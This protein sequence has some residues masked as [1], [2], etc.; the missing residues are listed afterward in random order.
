MLTAFKPS[1]ACNP[2]RSISLSVRP[3]LPTISLFPVGGTKIAISDTTLSVAATQQVVQSDDVEIGRWGSEDV[4]LD[5]AVSM[6]ATWSH[7]CTTA[8]RNLKEPN[9][10]NIS[11]YNPLFLYSSGDTETQSKRLS[12]TRS[13]WKIQISKRD[14]RRQHMN[15]GVRSPLSR[16]KCGNCPKPSGTDVCT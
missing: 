16:R 1:R 9:R 2:D 5:T 3:M 6:A 13:T 11:Q 14:Q 7:P 8:V 4:C 10:S 15:H 12:D